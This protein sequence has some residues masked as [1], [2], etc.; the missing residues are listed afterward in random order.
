MKKLLILLTLLSQILISA[1]ISSKIDNGVFK[2]KSAVYLTPK[3]KLTM[4]FNVKNAKSIKW[5]QIIPDTSKF[6]KNANHPWEKNAYQ[7]TGYG[8][9]DY[10]R[11]PI[12]SFENKKEVELTHDILEKNRPKNTPYYNS[13]L[14]SFWFEAEVVLSNGKVVK[15]SGINNIGRKGLS[16]K[17]LRVSYMAD[18]SYIGYLTTFFNVPGIFGSMPY[19]SRNYI[20]VD[21][22]D[23]LI[24]SSKVM[25]KAKNEKNYNVMMLV[26]KFKTK[27]KTQIVKGTPSKKLTW[28]KEFKQGDF[29]AVKYRKNGR[30]AHIGMLYGDENNNGVL[31]KKDSIINAGPNALHLTPLGKGAFDGTV[32][33]L[34]NEDLD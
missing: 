30:Y 1:E 12:K 28:G 13:K 34:K 9:L 6:Y 31:D 14:G 26:D 15:S 24:A 32:V 27:V 33:I 3:Q 19:Q 7:W 5:Y 4:R 16:P 11:V 20:G 21:C 23:V 8:K 17:V 29:I 22:A 25:N 2:Q 18:K 10:Q